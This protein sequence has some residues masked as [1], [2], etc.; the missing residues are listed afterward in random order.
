MTLLDSAVANPALVDPSI[1]SRAATFENPSGDRGAGGTTHNGRK[2]RPCKIIKAGQRVT[3]ADI[4]GPGVV[5]HIWMTFP[6]APPE[7]L[8]AL[9]VEVRYDGR[10]EPSVAAPCTDFFG[11]PH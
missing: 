9:Q 6:P 10:D 5:R 8:R 4:E 2:G 7:E 3:L 11:L 1:D